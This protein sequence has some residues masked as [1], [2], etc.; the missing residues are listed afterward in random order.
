MGVDGVW[1]AVWGWEGLGCCLSFSSTSPLLLVYG[2]GCLAVVG[3][4]FFFPAFLKGLALWH[5]RASP[6][7]R[8]SFPETSCWLGLK[9]SLISLHATPPHLCHTLNLPGDREWASECL[10]R[11]KHQMKWSLNHICKVSTSARF[12][13]GVDEISRTLLCIYCI[14]AFSSGT[15]FWSHSFS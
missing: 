13:W 4:F 11:S 12:C 10:L 8:A 9:S 5:K 14:H 2:V 7:R 1:A 15:L 6:E 3:F